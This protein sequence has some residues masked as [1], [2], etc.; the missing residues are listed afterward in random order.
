MTNDAR[1]AHPEKRM[2]VLARNVA[3]T[4][5]MASVSL[6]GCMAPSDS[7]P[8]IIASLEQAANGDP[9]SPPW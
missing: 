4:I 5:G 1:N 7:S 6:S 8:E 2:N 3:I 9:P